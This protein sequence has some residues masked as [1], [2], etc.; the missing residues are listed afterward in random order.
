MA[1][2]HWNIVGII[3]FQ[4]KENWLNTNVHVHEGKDGYHISYNVTLTQLISTRKHV[5]TD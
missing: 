5:L 3:T 4:D 2:S 1:A